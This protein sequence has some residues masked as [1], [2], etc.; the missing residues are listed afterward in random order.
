M[1]VATR[2]PPASE[3]DLLRAYGGFVKTL[4]RRFSRRAGQ[5]FE[6]SEGFQLGC[7]AMLRAV[8]A[9]DP[10]MIN[11]ETGRPYS[12]LT[13]IGLSVH[14][15]L[16]R[17]CEK[18]ERRGLTRRA[19]NLAVTETDETY[20]EVV[21]VGVLADADEVS[22]DLIDCMTVTDSSSDLVDNDEMWPIAQSVLDHREYWVLWSVY[23]QDQTDAQVARWLGLSKMRVG[24]IRK[25]ALEKLKPHLTEF[26]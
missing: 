21:N 2:P 26:A 22:P 18:Q 12:V 17:Y 6:P 3:E 24:Q 20:P 19:G 15:E 9:Y 8:R 4:V 10:T 7:M 13:T 14:R 5:E 1:Q 16:R 11:P 25:A 23:A